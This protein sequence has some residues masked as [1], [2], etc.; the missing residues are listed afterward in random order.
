[1]PSTS[2]YLFALI[3]LKAQTAGYLE[4]AETI[5]VLLLAYI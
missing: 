3:L 4:A 2:Q 5:N 1:M